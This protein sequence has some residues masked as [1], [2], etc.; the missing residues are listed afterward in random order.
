VVFE[1]SDAAS[2]SARI[3]AL[4][5][6]PGRAGH[7]APAHVRRDTAPA[8]LMQERLWIHG[9]LQPDSVAYNIPIAYRLRGQLDPKA[10]AD[11]I[12]A[13]VDRQASLRSAL[14]QEPDGL[15]LHVS[16]SAP[17]VQL[18]VDD[19]SALPPD[20]RARTL[21]ERFESLSKL[22]ID[23]ASPHPFHARLFRL[24]DTEW[25]LFFMP[26]HALWDGGSTE[27]FTQ[28]MAASCAA[29]G[30]RPATESALEF[31]YADFAIRHREQIAEASFAARKAE[32]AEAWRHHFES[33]G[34]PA[35]LPTDRPRDDTPARSAATARID[36]PG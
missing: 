23:L 31:D 2:L 21:D 17:P 19:L 10:L 5:A 9:Q 7:A 14:R 15:A 35:K 4:V 22:P 3:A 18:Q 11:A 30:G 20:Q 1:A 36:L 12:N 16:P 6:E 13:V 34:L 32:R 24:D 29:V 25:A 33:R 27:R 8:T 28:E 26:H